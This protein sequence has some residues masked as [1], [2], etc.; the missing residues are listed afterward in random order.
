[1]EQ[2]EKSDADFNQNIAKVGRTMD[3]ISNVMN[4]CVGILAYLSKGPQHY[5]QFHPKFVQHDTLLHLQNHGNYFT[6]N[7]RNF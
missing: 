5:S 4:Q 2:P 6:E 1:M 3:T 7:V